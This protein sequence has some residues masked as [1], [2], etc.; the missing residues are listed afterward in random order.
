MSKTPSPAQ[1]ARVLAALPL[2]RLPERPVDPITACCICGKSSEKLVLYRECN[3]WDAPL[4]GDQFRVYIGGDHDA[5]MK[6]ME[7]HPRLYTTERGMPGTFP[8]LCGPCVRRKG[9]SCASPKLKSNG[10]AGLLVNFS[11]IN[12]FICGRGGC[13]SAIGEA[14]TCD[15]QL[16]ENEVRAEESGPFEEIHEKPSA[17]AA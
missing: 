14:P 8:R 2:S 3:E 13:R 11:G 5:C 12:G 4:Q 16:F 10:G 15:D 17:G 1:R 6:T 7:K 9:T